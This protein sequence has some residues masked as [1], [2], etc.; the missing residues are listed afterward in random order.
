MT[1]FRYIDNPAYAKA[2][3]DGGPHPLRLNS[4]YKDVE[5]KGIRTPDEGSVLLADSSTPEQLSWLTT[6][7]IRV[8]QA[9]HDATKALGVG[10]L[11]VFAADPMQDVIDDERCALPRRT[12][13]GRHQRLQTHVAHLRQRRR[14][15]ARPKRSMG[16]FPIPAIR[17]STVDDSTWLR[18][19]YF[20][21]RVR[22]FQKRQWAVASREKTD[23]AK[24]RARFRRCVVRFA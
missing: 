12:R 10:R 15:A 11:A 20:S 21:S 22:V 1:K 13:A 6:S 16:Y 23:V 7:L 3:I 2:W 18:E 8:L 17:I 24:N 4:F 19:T 9:G 5:R 14:S